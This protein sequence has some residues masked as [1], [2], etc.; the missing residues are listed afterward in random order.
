MSKKV[1]LDTN[2]PIA[3]IFHLNSSYFRAKDA[4]EQYDEFFLVRFCKRRI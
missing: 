4:F 2:L 1:F 3:F